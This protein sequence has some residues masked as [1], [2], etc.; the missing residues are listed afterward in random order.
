[1]ELATVRSGRLVCDPKDANQLRSAQEPTG[2]RIRIV[3]LLAENVGPRTHN[4]LDRVP[5]LCYSARE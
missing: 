5:F 2:G 4:R 1:M 3:S